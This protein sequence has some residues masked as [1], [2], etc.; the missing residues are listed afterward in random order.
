M[1]G[2]RQSAELSN[3]LRTG[4]RKA[5]DGLV[6]GAYEELHRMAHRALARQGGPLTMRTTGLLHETYLKLVGQER[7]TVSDRSHFMAVA[8]TAMRHIVI[9]HV[10]G[11]R[12]LKRGGGAAPRTLGEEDAPV[13]PDVDEVIDVD[14]ALTRLERFDERLVR[15]VE[16][17]FFAGLTVEETAAALGLAP[18]T[19]DR[20]WQK[21]KAWLH[22]EIH[23]AE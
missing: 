19:V 3:A 6:A 18:R 12:R 17:R 13:E 7:L 4:D 11:R 1:S 8:A 22:R 10:R 23:E 14:K 16:C 2:R 20:A 21:A 15:V 9:D 5:L